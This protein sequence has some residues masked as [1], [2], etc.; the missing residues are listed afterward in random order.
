MD[1]LARLCAI[2][3]VIAASFSAVYCDHDDRSSVYFALMVSSTPTLN[4]SGVVSAVGQALERVNNDNSNVLPGVR[5]Q[6]TSVL[7]SQVSTNI[8]CVVLFL[9]IL[10]GMEGATNKQPSVELAANCVLG[11]KFGPTF[12]TLP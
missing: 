5:L 3:L 8:I 7:D 4:T 1:L 9:L 10:N 12:N 11:D 2:S 6:Y